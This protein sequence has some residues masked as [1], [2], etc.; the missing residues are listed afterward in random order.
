LGGRLCM[1]SGWSVSILLTAVTSAESHHAG[2]HLM[3]G[4]P[5]LDWSWIPYCF[6]VID[7]P[8]WDEYSK[9]RIAPGWAYP[10]GRNRIERALRTAGARVGSLSLDGP[11]LPPR[12]GPIAVFDVF[13]LGDARAGYFW[14][15]P[16]GHSALLM[17]WTAVPTGQRLAI[18]SQLEAGWLDR[19][20]EWAAG[21]LVRG[22]A[23]SASEHRFLVTAENTKLT[24][25]EY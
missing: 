2:L 21:A 24:L 12:P 8:P 18:A 17:R 15:S 4:S 3:T 5:A 1:V 11:D 9:G 20:C 10:L 14:E 25:T 16:G 23:W 13:W 6:L 19:G 22:N 7:D